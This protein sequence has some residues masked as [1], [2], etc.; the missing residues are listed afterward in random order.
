[1]L[2]EFFNN[3]VGMKFSIFDNDGMFYVNCVFDNLG[4][5]WFNLC[6]NVYFNGLWF[7]E[8]VFYF[9]FL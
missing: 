1:M 5:W 2:S 4:G 8:Y 7:L 3:Y 6:Y 9:W